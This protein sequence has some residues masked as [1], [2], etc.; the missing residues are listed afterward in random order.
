MNT[1]IKTNFD[2]D[3]EDADDLFAALVEFENLSNKKRNTLDQIESEYGIEISEKFS[4][5][6]TDTESRVIQIDK[7]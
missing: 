3:L 1:K 7:A 5:N 4:Y 6:G 2:L